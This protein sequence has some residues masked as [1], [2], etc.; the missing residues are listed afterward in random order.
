MSIIQVPVAVRALSKSEREGV[1]MEF[2][3]KR[4]GDVLYFCYAYPDFGQE[5]IQKT[6]IVDPHPIYQPTILVRY[7]D[8]A[9][10]I[11]IPKRNLRIFLEQLGLSNDDVW[12][13][14]QSSEIV[15][16]IEE[17]LDNGKTKYMDYPSDFIKNEIK[18]RTFSTTY[19]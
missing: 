14:S 17:I 15:F 18:S 1:R 2:Y 6:W 16:S 11:V 9:D 8:G 10:E 13:V 7:H 4:D 12:I 3:V 5:Y 19:I